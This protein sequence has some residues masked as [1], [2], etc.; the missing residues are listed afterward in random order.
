MTIVKG[1]L[2]Q[3]IYPWDSCPRGG[4]RQLEA[5]SPRGGWPPWGVLRECRLGM[6]FASLPL[7]SRDDVAMTIRHGL[8][9]APAKIV[10]RRRNTMRHG[11][12]FAPAKI[13]GRSRNDSDIKFEKRR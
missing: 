13:A 7:R 9:F 2:W 4:R 3:E 5:A 6:G 1:H 10:G 11:L 8:R 12:R